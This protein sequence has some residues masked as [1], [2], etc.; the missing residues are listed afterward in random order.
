MKLRYFPAQRFKRG[1]V[2][3]NNLIGGP[4][5]RE[6]T[7]Y[8]DRATVIDKQERTIFLITLRHGQLQQLRTQRLNHRPVF[9]FCIYRLKKTKQIQ[10]RRCGNYGSYR[11]K[12]CAR[13]RSHYFTSL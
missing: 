2:L 10:K 5:C 3:I 12:H 1:S 13:L 8:T 11:I 4:Q 7:T 6:A 9:S